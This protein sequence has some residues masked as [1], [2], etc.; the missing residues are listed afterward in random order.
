V[1]A[2]RPR[3]SGVYVEISAGVSTAVALGVPAHVALDLLREMAAGVNAAMKK[4]HQDN[5]G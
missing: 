3:S 5:E 4:L 1:A 2:L